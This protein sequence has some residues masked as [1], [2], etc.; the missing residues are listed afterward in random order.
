MAKRSV[1]KTRRLQDR[2]N[3]DSA[4]EIVSAKDFAGM[5]S[6]LTDEEIKNAIRIVNDIRLK[7]AGKQNTS[8][9]LENMR[10]E[11]L[12]RLAEINVLATFDPTPV[13]YEEP[14]TVEIIGK[15]AP[16]PIHKY[17]FD[18]ERK[19]HEVLGAVERNE[20]YRGQK[21]PYNKRKGK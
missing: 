20:D 13:F 18:H 11:I 10:D 15:I 8:T 19:R 6:D 4:N 1:A 7:W 21:E 5:A 16:D 12:T 9:N 14:P 2:F 17:G 3:V